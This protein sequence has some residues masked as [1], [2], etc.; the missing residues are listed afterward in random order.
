MYEYT[1]SLRIRSYYYYY[2]S[3]PF[4][5]PIGST[6]Y[7]FCSLMIILLL[8]FLFPFSPIHNKVR[9]DILTLQ[10]HAELKHQYP[11]VYTIPCEN[12]MAIHMS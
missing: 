12:F 2:H 6:L 4:F 8:G 9:N 7:P 1:F 11:P 3:I 10:M 5:L